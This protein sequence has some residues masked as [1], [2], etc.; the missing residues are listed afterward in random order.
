MSEVLLWGMR[1]RM[2]PNMTCSTQPDWEQCVAR[3]RRKVMVCT[4]YRLT[5]F[6]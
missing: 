3:E 6:G 4:V 1:I 2:L 5:F